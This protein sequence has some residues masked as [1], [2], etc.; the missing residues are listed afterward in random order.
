MFWIPQVL[1]LTMYRDTQ[2]EDEARFG[3]V[4][5]RNNLVNQI[6]IISLTVLWCVV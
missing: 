3:E 6:I 1:Q 5:F 2:E 4:L